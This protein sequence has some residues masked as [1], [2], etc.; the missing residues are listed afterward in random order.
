MRQ[1]A[2]DIKLWILMGITPVLVMIIG[3]LIDKDLNS[4]KDTQKELAERLSKIEGLHEQVAVNTV[5]IS[6]LKED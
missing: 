3:Y 2:T 1:G 6:N 4:I 5:N